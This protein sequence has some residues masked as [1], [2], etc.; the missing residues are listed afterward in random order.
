MS[1]SPDHSQGEAAAVESVRLQDVFAAN[2]IYTGIEVSSLKR[3]IEEMA[4]RFASGSPQ[5]LDKEVV[6]R[7]LLEREQI[8]STWVS[9]GVA[10]PH[11]R[12]DSISEAVG[13][14][15]R[16]KAPLCIDAKD[17]KFVCVACGLLVPME[18]ADAH[19]R[20]LATLARAFE[21]HDLYARLMA[22]DDPG[23]LH[24]ELVKAESEIAASG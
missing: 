2:R 11:C 12:L 6:F 9:D 17:D 23:E 21:R 1:D 10:I 4:E 13:V 20:V 16:M 3:M 18:C 19:I 7:A 14:I 24:S 22:A 5:P 15:L 8:G